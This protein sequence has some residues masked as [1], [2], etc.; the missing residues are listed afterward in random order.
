MNLISVS[1]AE[2][3]RENEQEKVCPVM[4]DW[5]LRQFRLTK[6]DLNAFLIATVFS[7]KLQNEK[8]F[9]HIDGRLKKVIICW[10]GSNPSLYSDT[11]G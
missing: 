1:I 7:R 6:L 5:K 8:S 9:G 11:Q 3:E 2:R 10:S 4:D